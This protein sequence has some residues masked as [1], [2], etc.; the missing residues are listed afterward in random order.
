MEEEGNMEHMVHMEN[1]QHMD[2]MH[3]IVPVALLKA[4]P[5]TEEE[6]AIIIQTQYRGY[7]VRRSHPLDKLRLIYNVH[8][9]LKSHMQKLAEPGQ[10]DKLC[11]DSQERLRWSECAMALLLQLDS[12]QGAPPDVR[13]MRRCITK[14]VITFQEIIDSTTKDIGSTNLHDN[15]AKDLHDGLVLLRDL[16]FALHQL[17]WMFMHSL[18]MD[19]KEDRCT[20]V[21]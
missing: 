13:D 10:F 7:V 1:T 4:P 11:K 17:G 16:F 12:I 18:E 21:M 3:N 8:M 2:N 6:A 19:E 9:D 14:E 5:P 15:D 20:T